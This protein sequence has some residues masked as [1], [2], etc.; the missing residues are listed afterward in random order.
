M[1]TPAWRRYLGVTME[2]MGGIGVGCLLAAPLL[3]PTID[4]AGIFLAAV[5]LYVAGLFVTLRAEWA[6]WHVVAV[7]LAFVGGF[8]NGAVFVGPALD[9]L[10][11][12]IVLAALCVPG[13]LVLVFWPPASKGV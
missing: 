9:L 2:T 7:G 13:G 4:S 3:I 8:V 11:P 6:L 5:S 1:N 10:V 12:N